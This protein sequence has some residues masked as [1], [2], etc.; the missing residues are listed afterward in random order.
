MH[1]PTFLLPAIFYAEGKVVR[2]LHQDGDV[3]EKDQ[4]YVEVEAMKMIMAIKVSEQANV[5]VDRIY[6][7]N[8]APHNFFTSSNNLNFS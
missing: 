3:V 7:F 6:N 4:P 1:L 8:P 5:L 2:L